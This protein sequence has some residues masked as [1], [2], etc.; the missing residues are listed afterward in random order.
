MIHEP[1]KSYIMINRISYSESRKVQ[2]LD[3]T[4][5]T[6]TILGILGIT[7]LRGILNANWEVLYGTKFHIPFGGT[8][9]ISKKVMADLS[10]VLTNELESK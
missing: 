1:I 3:L 7:T 8:A 10:S 2:D 9:T 5:R 4:V 6:K